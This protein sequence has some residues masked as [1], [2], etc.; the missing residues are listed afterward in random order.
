M[1]VKITWSL[2]V[3]VASG[4]KVAGTDTLEVDAYDTIEVT[5]PKKSGADGTATAELQPLAADK[6]KLLVI[7]SS[8]YKD[9]TYTVDG[10]AAGVKL[11]A[12]QAFIGAGTVGLLGPGPKKITFTN[13]GTADALVQILVGRKAA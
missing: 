7:K 10:G 4:P 2:N 11:D 5:V 6:V 13:A 12:Q 8:V 1:A 9:L 3:Q